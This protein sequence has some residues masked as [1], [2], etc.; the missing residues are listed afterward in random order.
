M[1]KNLNPYRGNLGFT[2][3]LEWE[4]PGRNIEP[5]MNYAS[6]VQPLIR[7]NKEGWTTHDNQS[8][9]GRTE[10]WSQL[11]VYWSSKDRLTGNELISSITLER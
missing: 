6:S 1:V 8:T 4:I 11:F 2:Q 5:L 9:H 3:I 10:E 7:I